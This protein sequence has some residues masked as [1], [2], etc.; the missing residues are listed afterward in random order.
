MKRMSIERFRDLL[1]LHG[2]DLA[3]WPQLDGTEA[4]VLVEL[5]AQARAMLD[6]ARRLDRAFVAS[7]P[8]AASAALHLRILEALPVRDRMEHVPS[9]SLWETL[10]GAIGG[11]RIAGPAF[12][13]ALT[14]GIALGYGAAD[15]PAP[16]LIDLAGFND[17][18]IEY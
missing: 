14:L 18:D 8:E 7:R 9:G 6:G 15:L 12:V 16:D 4:A 10:V 17:F 3:R 5:D 2:S 11:W 1:D 13:T